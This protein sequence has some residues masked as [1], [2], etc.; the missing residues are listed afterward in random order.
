MKALIGL[1]LAGIL[2]GVASGYEYA[3][4]YNCDASKCRPPDCRCARTTSPLPLDQTPQ[5]ILVTNDDA[6]ESQVLG[7]MESMLRG[8]SQKNGCPIPVTWFTLSD[9]TDCTLVKER[10][11]GG[12][13]FACHTKTHKEL[14]LKTPRSEMEDEIL[15]S[16]GFLVEGCG[17]PATSVVGFRNTYLVSTPQSRE[18]MNKFGFLYDSSMTFDWGGEDNAGANR[19]FPFTLDYGVPDGTCAPDDKFQSCN[20]EERYKGLWE[21]PVWEMKSQDGESYG[22]DPGAASP[23]NGKARPVD[24]VLKYNFDAAYGGNRA[25]LPLYV[26]LGWF[27]EKHIEQTQSFLKYA[28]SKPDVYFLTMQQMVNWMQAPVPKTEMADWLSNRCGGKIPMSPPP[29]S[30][31]PRPLSFLSLDGKAK[32]ALMGR[33]LRAQE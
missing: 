15:G 9:G 17:L 6:V 32:V 5:I 19:S 28:M 3:D 26:H 22:M 24:E 21:M 30:P 31:P 1:F 29:P 25:P 2:V 13:E 8:F 20:E 18:I 23:G 11:K 7:N 10:F 14:N 27:S 4:W 33:R 12:D 16:R